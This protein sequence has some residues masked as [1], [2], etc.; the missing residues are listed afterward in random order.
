M[1]TFV[2]VPAKGVGEIKADAWSLKG[3]Y[4]ITGSWSKDETGVIQIKLK[5]TFLAVTLDPK[6]FNGQFDA[7]RDALTG[8]WGSSADLENSTEKME[9]RRIAPH[10]LAVYPNMKELSGDKVRSLWRFAISAVRNDI[11]RNHWLWAYFSQRRDDRE[12]MVPLMVRSRYFGPPLRLEE[13]QPLYIIGPR[14]TSAD[15]CFYDSKAYHILTHTWVH[16]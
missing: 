10:Y 15:A 14:Q 4:T 2:L 5:M 11:R 6:F 8:V 3:R 1:M 12:T 7:E 9:C 16:E 13:I